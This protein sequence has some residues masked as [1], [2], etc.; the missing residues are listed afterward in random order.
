[1]FEYL[2]YADVGQKSVEMIARKLQKIT[3]ILAFQYCLEF[4]QKSFVYFIYT[5]KK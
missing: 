4:I 3:K 5:E 1:M 2:P